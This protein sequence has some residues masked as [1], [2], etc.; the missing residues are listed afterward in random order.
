MKEL[1]TPRGRSRRAV[2]A[3]PLRR[4]RRRA[5]PRRPPRAGGR[6]RRWRGRA[7]PRASGRGRP[8]PPP[9]RPNSP[10]GR[11]PGPGPARRR[12]A[13]AHPGTFHAGLAYSRCDARLA[14]PG[15]RYR[16]T[17]CAVCGR[18]MPPSQGPR[19]ERAHGPDGDVRTPRHRPAP[20]VGLW[21]SAPWRSRCRNACRTRAFGARPSARPSA[22]PGSWRYS[23]CLPRLRARLRVRCPPGI[24]EG[25]G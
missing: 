6:G 15:C 17:T 23:W 5:G 21:E 10:G 1:M 11:A 12:R 19:R 2:T 3:K 13:G 14:V 22:C 16:P 4:K 24:H 25:S 8:R 20:A 9:A 18:A 7:S